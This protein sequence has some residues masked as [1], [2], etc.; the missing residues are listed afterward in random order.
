VYQFA[1]GGNACRGQDMPRGV[2]AVERDRSACAPSAGSRKLQTKR[3][4][5]PGVACSRAPV[6]CNPK[7]LTSLHVAVSHPDSETSDSVRYDV[8]RA[9]RQSEKH[10]IIGTNAWLVVVVVLTTVKRLCIKKLSQSSSSY[11]S[12][13]WLVR[14]ASSRSSFGGSVRSA[15]VLQLIFN[16]DY[17]C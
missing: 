15:Y 7:S 10:Y 14:L 6:V 16:V 9:H 12:T 2:A 4:R 13:P 8:P 3:I 5:T 11:T 17:V 1:A